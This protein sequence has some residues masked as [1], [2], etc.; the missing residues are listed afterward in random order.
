MNLLSND[1][2][3]FD[4]PAQFALDRA[5]LDERWKN[6]QRE[7]HPDRFTTADAQAQRQAMQWSVRIN[8]AY[9]RLKDPLKRAAYLCE[10]NGAPIQAE[11]NTSMP[12]AFLM[13]QMQWREDLDEASSAEDL[14]RMADD[15]AQTRRGM[16][17]GLQ[18][19][20][21]EERNFLELARQVRALMFVERFARDVENRLD[22][23][24][25]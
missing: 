9:Q 5:S 21:D 15:V 13:Q 8:E 1:F 6:L 23:L 3:I 20:A 12:A 11:N 24:G 25:Q 19:T 22:Q 17:L 2:E 4:V 16:L 14:E 18:R 7:A 10:L